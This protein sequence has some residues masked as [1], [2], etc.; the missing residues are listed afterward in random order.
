MSD[1]KTPEEIAKEFLDQLTP[2][3]KITAGEPKTIRDL[4]KFAG[5]LVEPINITTSE[6]LISAFCLDGE[7]YQMNFEYRKASMKTSE[8]ALEQLIKKGLVRPIFKDTR[9]ITYRYI[10]PPPIK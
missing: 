8:A 10:G 9:I 5:K 4:L 3:R 1:K 6:Q 7:P 2:R